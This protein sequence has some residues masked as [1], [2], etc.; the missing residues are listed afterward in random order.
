M[1]KKSAKKT[2]KAKTTKKKLLVPIDIDRRREWRFNLPLPTLV[3]GKLPRGKNFKEISKLE[4][5]SS[6]GAYFRLDSGLVVGSKLSLIIDVPK[7][8]TEGRTVKLQIGGITVRLEK[9]DKKRKKQGVAVHF[10]KDFKFVPIHK[11]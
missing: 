9:A 11:K 5:I 2:T 3:E 6:S 1:Q 10:S 4:N 7:K 8:V